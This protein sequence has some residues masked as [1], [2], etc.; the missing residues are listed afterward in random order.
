MAERM[1]AWPLSLRANLIS[2]R[3]LFWSAACWAALAAASISDSLSCLRR[4]SSSSY[5]NAAVLHVWFVCIIGQLVCSLVRPLKPSVCIKVHKSRCESIACPALSYQ[6]A[7]N[8]GR[9]APTRTLAQQ[10]QQHAA[11]TPKRCLLVCQPVEFTSPML[12]Y[13]CIGRIGLLGNW[14]SMQQWV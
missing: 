11:W 14:K 12:C 9:E 4:D 8:R 7:R 10:M 3:R 2:R 1:R 5:M 6:H 13:R